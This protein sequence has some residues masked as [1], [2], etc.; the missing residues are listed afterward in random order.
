[1]DKSSMEMTTSKQESKI[2]SSRLRGTVVELPV[3]AASIADALFGDT[4]G[5]QKIRRRLTRDLKW[6]AKLISFGRW[7]TISLNNAALIGCVAT[8]W[9]WKE[10]DCAMYLAEQYNKAGLSD[11][12]KSPSYATVV[13][14]ASEELREAVTHCSEAP[15]LA[16]LL[17]RTMRQLVSSDPDVRRAALEMTEASAQVDRSVREIRRYVG[18]VERVEDDDALLVVTNND[19]RDELRSVEAS[20]VTK[21]AADDPDGA[22]VMYELQWSPDTVTS[23]FIPAMWLGSGI[24]TDEWAKKEVELRAREKALPAAVDIN[25]EEL[26]VAKKTATAGDR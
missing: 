25:A 23:Y 15:N 17:V 1:M 9:R 10:R 3:V 4:P 21:L 13:R 2:T 6:P 5:I 16:H 18:Y 11:I 20:A 12:L 19:G 24:S 22:F 26:V 8:A 14:R 7:G